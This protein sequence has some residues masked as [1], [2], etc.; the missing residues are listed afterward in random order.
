[1]ATNP[2]ADIHTLYRP[3][4]LRANLANRGEATFKGDLQEI[5]E[6]LQADRQQS[7]DATR[8]LHLAAQLLLQ[9]EAARLAAFTPGDPRIAALRAGAARAVEQSQF[10]AEEAALAGVRIPMVRKTEALMHGRVTDDANR[11]AGPV[12]VTLVGADGQ[13]VEGVAAVEADSA[14][15]YALIVPAEVAARLPADGRYAVS[16]QH[17]AERIAP[18]FEPQP[19]K[20]GAVHLQDLTLTDEELRKLKVRSEFPE[21]RPRAAEPA[22]AHAKTGAPRK[23][24]G[25]AGDTKHPH[26]PQQPQEPEHPGEPGD[27]GDHDK[28]A[29]PDKPR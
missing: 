9:G 16:V 29:K 21:L 1:M 2:S 22:K 7:L 20:A 4:R 18:R 28:P 15:Y 23:A 26:E 5:V 24:T 8:H 19:L 12:T 11:P 10:L 17:G 3:E 14:G 25:H 13:P 6:A 27:H